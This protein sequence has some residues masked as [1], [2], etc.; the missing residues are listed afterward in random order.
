MTE[1]AQRKKKNKRICQNVS[2]MFE[3]CNVTF[4]IHDRVY[5]YIFLN[6]LDKTIRPLLYKISYLAKW[7]KLQHI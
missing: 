2:H 6:K 7:L 1:A 4:W 5:M 3:I